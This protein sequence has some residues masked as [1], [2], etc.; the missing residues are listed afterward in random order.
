MHL[1]DHMFPLYFDLVILEFPV[2]V[3][4]ASSQRHEVEVKPKHWSVPPGP[5]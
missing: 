1:V 3:L 2:F 5:I 4:G